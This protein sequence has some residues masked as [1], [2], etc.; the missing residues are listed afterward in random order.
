VAQG[1]SRTVLT[2]ET[3]STVYGWP[4]DVV[5]HAAANGE[6]SGPLVVPRLSSPPGSPS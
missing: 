3:L 5:E 6:A 4:I 2:G 1:E